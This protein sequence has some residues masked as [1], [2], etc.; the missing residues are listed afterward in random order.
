M[1]LAARARPHR[2]MHSA[3]AHPPP[4]REQ[5][6]PRRTRAR[7]GSRPSRIPHTARAVEPVFWGS[8]RSDD[9]CATAAREPGPDSPTFRAGGRISAACANSSRIRPT[10]SGSDAV[11][12]TARTAADGTRRHQRTRRVRRRVDPPPGRATAADPGG[13][14]TIGHGD[15]RRAPRGL[16]TMPAARTA[17]DRG[18][19]IRHRRSRL[20]TEG[21]RRA[22]VN[23]SAVRCPRNSTTST[24]KSRA[25][26]RATERSSDL[27]RLDER[28]S[29]AR[30]RDSAQA[31]ATTVANTS[32]AMHQRPLPVVGNAAWPG[33]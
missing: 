25:E 30:W 14:P 23:V 2:P 32:A 7:H 13:L 16:H 33:R 11:G 5:H 28:S 26:A 9:L 1:R 4:T 21:T 18:L 8:Y 10:A 12:R 17:N 19:G 31:R 29:I 3:P 22:L 24:S 6:P 20:E 15:R 27:H